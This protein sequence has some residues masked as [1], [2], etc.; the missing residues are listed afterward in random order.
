MTVDELLINVTLN[1][2]QLN[3]SI[4]NAESQLN[5]FAHN[6]S[7]VVGGALEM[8]ALKFSVTFGKDLIETFANAGTKLNVLSQ[9]IGENVGTLD[10]WGAAVQKAGGSADS[11]YN[12]VNNLHNRLVDMKIGG[13]M[14]SS[15]IFGLLGISIENAAHQLKKPSEILLELSSKLKG[16]SQEFQQYI[17]RQLGIDEAT[18]RVLSKGREETLKLVAAQKQ[19]WDNKNSRQAMQARDNIIDFDR[20]LEQLKNT[21]AVKLLPVA[22]KF[23]GWIEQMVDKH[24]DA[25]SNFIANLADGFVTMS[26]AIGNFVSSHG[27]EVVEVLGKIVGFIKELVLNY[28]PAIADGFREFKK[29]TGLT[30]GGL[31]K[32]LGAF[33]AL[34]AITG[35]IGA[36]S[37][38]TKILG[39]LLGALSAPLTAIVSSIQSIKWIYDMYQEYESNPDKFKEDHKVIGGALDKVFKFGK[40]IGDLAA[41]MLIPSV[42]INA[43]EKTG[44]K[45]RPDEYHAVAQRLAPKIAQIESSGGKNIDSNNG[46]YG[47]YQVRPNWGN[48]ARAQAGLPPQSPEWYK[49]ANNSYSTYMLM[50]KQNLATTKGDINKAIEM[51]SGKNYGL[52]QVMANT[53]KS[54]NPELIGLN[55]PNLSSPQ[56]MTASSQQQAKPMSN[57]QTQTVTI[58]NMNVKADNVDD[59]LDSVQSKINPAFAFNNSPRTA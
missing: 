10:K 50:M 46:A 7:T 38:A 41:D 23:M 18:I 25:I 4:Q 31:V 12:T 14:K 34:K 32:L 13:D 36:I 29:E 43:P 58:Q 49:D 19:L 54:Y 37:A 15:S 5:K 39:G 2:K 22:F 42:D 44:R 9:Q 20:R 11:F 51:Y 47:A 21:I 55:N 28:L 45:V 59:L 1:A 30:S 40:G 52:N 17:G 6:I 57:N 3:Q 16:Q 35:V 56:A 8:L 33:M 53:G 48:K 26:M 27:K 24:S